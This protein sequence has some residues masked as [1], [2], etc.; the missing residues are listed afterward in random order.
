MLHHLRLL[1]PLFSS[2]VFAIDITTPAIVFFLPEAGN[3]LICFISLCL[4]VIKHLFERC[5]LKSR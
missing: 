1:Y 5:A 4:D 2:R 3:L